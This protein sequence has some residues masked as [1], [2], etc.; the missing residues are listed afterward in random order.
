MRFAGANDIIIGI[1]L[2]QDLPH[3]LH[4]FGCITPIAPRVQIAEIERVFPA[5]E[6]RGHAARD[7]AR[8]KGLAAPRTLVIE[9]DAA[10]GVETITLPV[11]PGYR[12]RINLGRSV[13]ASRLKHGRFALRRWSGAEHFRTRRLIKPGL[14]PAAADGFEQPHRAE[15]SDVTCVFGNIEAYFHMAL[16]C[17]MVQLVRCKAVDQ[18]QNPFGG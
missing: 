14:R 15:A 4:V 12:M 9:Q 18:I 6:N 16:C 5:S 13:R 1:I 10:R 3:C 2:L 7:L 17:E 8:H 11:N